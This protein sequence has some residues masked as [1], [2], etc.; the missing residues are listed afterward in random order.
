LPESPELPKSP[1]LETQLSFETRKNRLTGARDDEIKNQGISLPITKT[2]TT[3]EG[4][5][6]VRSALLSGILIGFSQGCK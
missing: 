2:E 5:A 6:T 4:F 1:K 3:T